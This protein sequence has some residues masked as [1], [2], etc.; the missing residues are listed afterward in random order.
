MIHVNH[1]VEAVSF[2]V[3]ESVAEGFQTALEMLL[4][5]G[6]KLRGDLERVKPE[7]LNLHRFAC[8][9]SNDPFTD[10]RVHPGELHAALTSSQQAVAVHANTEA[11][12]TRVTIKNREDGVLERPFV[13]R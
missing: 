6:R 4:P 12:A 13:L 7:R 10:F 1:V 9:G 11:C 2:L 3:P 5:T 8:A